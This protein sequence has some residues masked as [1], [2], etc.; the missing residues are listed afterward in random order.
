MLYTG[1]ADTDK[2]L[3]QIKHI[4]LDKKIKQVDIVN[5]T[6]LNKVTISHLL[7][8]KSKNVTLD[9]LVMLCNAVDCQLE[10]NIVPDTKE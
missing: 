5:K 2:L 6:G 1:S 10:I 7:S 3:L 4:M 9:T 8:G